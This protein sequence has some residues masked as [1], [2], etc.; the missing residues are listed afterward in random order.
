MKV[1]ADLGIIAPRILE[2]INRQRNK[3][4]HDY[5][6]PTKEDVEDALDISVLF[7][8]YTSNLNTKCR[9]EKCSGENYDAIVDRKQGMLTVTEKGEEPRFVKIGNDEDWLKL[10]KLL[11]LVKSQF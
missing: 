3:L 1:I 4:E 2:K 5:I 11:R 7:L 6:Q 8:G 10:A 9:I